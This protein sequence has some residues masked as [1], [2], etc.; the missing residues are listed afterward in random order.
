MVARNRSTRQRHPQVAPGLDSQA[1]LGRPSENQRK[2]YR[3]AWD[4]IHAN[5][6]IMTADT[7][8]RELAERRFQLHDSFLPNRYSALFHGVGL[9]DEYPYLPYREDFESFGHDGVV[10]PGMVLCAESYV[11]EVGGE[12]GVELEQQVLITESG[13]NALSTY[14]FEDDLLGREI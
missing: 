5:V 7:G 6:E 14:P 9:C 3:V 13:P 10:E 4:Q 2:F 11:G 1:G 8:F 12:E